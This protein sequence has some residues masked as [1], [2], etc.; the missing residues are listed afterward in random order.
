MDADKKKYLALEAQLQSKALKKINIWKNIAIAASTLGVAVAYTGISGIGLNLF[1]GI[2]GVI[3]IVSGSA[4]ALILNL[5]L[6]N[7][8]K[9]V[10]KILAALERI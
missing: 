8:R 9:N 10:E 1:L 2:L 6:K 7:G 5:G 3:L 4:I